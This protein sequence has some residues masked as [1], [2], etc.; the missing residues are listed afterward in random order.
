MTDDVTNDAPTPG[1]E[2]ATGPGAVRR[3]TPE[4]YSEIVDTA[5]DQVLAE[6]SGRATCADITRRL[7]ENVRNLP[8]R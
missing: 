2:S 4:R 1:D 5:I 8:P 3:M 6:T 7:H